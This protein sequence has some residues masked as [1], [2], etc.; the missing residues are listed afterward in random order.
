LLVKQIKIAIDFFF[1]MHHNNNCHSKKQPR[2]T[3][4]VPFVRAGTGTI[5]MPHTDG[6]RAIVRAQAFSFCFA[7][8]PKQLTGRWQPRLLLAANLLGMGPAVLT[9]D[10]WAFGGREGVEQSRATNNT[11]SE[12]PIWRRLT[13]GTYKGVNA[14]RKALD[15]AGMRIGDS[16]DEILGRPASPFSSSKTELDLVVGYGRRPRLRTR[17]HGRCGDRS[18][19]PAA[20]T[21]ALSRRNW[22]AAPAA[23]CEPAGRRVSPYRNASRR[24]LSRRSRRYD[25]GQWR[26]WTVAAW[27]R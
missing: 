9:S 5:S 20:R 11:T 12:F 25:G 24:H 14:I 27:R 17:Q 8:D 15:G 22:A 4:G 26:R 1:I 16:A 3:R 7:R 13:I 21:R 19:R 2:G 6:A 23:I 18:A 10:V